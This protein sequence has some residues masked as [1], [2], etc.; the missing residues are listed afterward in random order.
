MGDTDQTI[1]NHTLN[2]NNYYKRNG[3]LC[4]LWTTAGLL[5][6]QEASVVAAAICFVTI[7]LVCN[8]HVLTWEIQARR[9]QNG[10]AG[11]TA[12]QKYLYEYLYS[13]SYVNV[14]IDSALLLDITPSVLDASLH[15]AKNFA[16]RNK[17]YSKKITKCSSNQARVHVCMKSLLLLL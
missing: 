9:A 5:L 11:T 12:V 13:Y 10:L 17:K 14:D 1:N 6:L 2:R 7:C 3:C 8:T 15:L 16:L 4:D